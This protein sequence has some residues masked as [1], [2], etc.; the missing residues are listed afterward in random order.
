MPI[1]NGFVTEVVPI[2][3]VG[4]EFAFPAFH[5][6]GDVIGCKKVNQFMYDYKLTQLFW[7]DAGG[8]YPTL[9]R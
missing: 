2:L 6:I 4:G 5:R 1:A 8:E 3:R 9:Y 7:G